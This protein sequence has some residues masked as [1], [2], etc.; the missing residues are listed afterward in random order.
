M[1]GEEPVWEPSEYS[2]VVQEE[3]M[4]NFR[5]LLVDQEAITRGRR[6]INSVSPT[7]EDLNVTDFTDDDNFYEAL[8]YTVKVSILGVSRVGVSKRKKGINHH[9]LS[10]NWM[11]SPQTALRTVKR[12]T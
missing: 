12:T 1:T 4:T 10:N 9:T 7:S 3:A 5:G 11:F 6:I 2:F 8:I